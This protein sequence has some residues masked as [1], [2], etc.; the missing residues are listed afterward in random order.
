MV[1]SACNLVATI[2]G[3]V[4]ADER[5]LAVTGLL[6]PLTLPP[7]LLLLHNKCKEPHIRKT[8]RRKQLNTCKLT[9]E[10]K[11]RFHNTR[12]LQQTI[13]EE[14]VE[15]HSYAGWRTARIGRWNL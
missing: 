10:N 9:N 5:P 1:E 14:S 8:T 12:A 11:N 4:G 3:R 7:P 6:P 13:T 15:T 2:E